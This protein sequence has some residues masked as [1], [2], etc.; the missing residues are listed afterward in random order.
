M[1]IKIQSPEFLNKFKN[2]LFENFFGFDSEKTT[3]FIDFLKEHNVSIGG[4]YI[5]A[6]L[7]DIDNYNAEP[8]LII[9]NKNAEKF[10]LNMFPGFVILETSLSQHN[11][12]NIYQYIQLTF[13]KA[14][15][16]SSCNRIGE[17]GCLIYKENDVYNLL[18]FLKDRE[19]ISLFEIWY[20]PIEDK[21]NIGSIELLKKNRGEIKYIGKY[22]GKNIKYEIY[23]KNKLCELLKKKDVI[24][25][26]RYIQESISNN[27]KDIEKD[28]ILKTIGA[29]TDPYND[30]LDGSE[31]MEIR[32]RVVYAYEYGEIMKY[33]LLSL[34]HIYI[35]EN[36]ISSKYIS[37]DLFNHIS[38]YLLNSLNNKDYQE[39]FDYWVAYFMT[40]YYSK[41]ISILCDNILKSI[42]LNKIEKCTYNEFIEA[43]NY[44][45]KP[46]IKS[47]KIRLLFDIIIAKKFLNN[48]II[49]IS[50][51]NKKIKFNLGDDS[52]LLSD[53]D[54]N[55][56]LFYYKN[57]IYNN[58]LKYKYKFIDL[59]INKFNLFNINVNIHTETGSNSYKKYNDI[60]LNIQE[61]FSRLLRGDPRIIE[62]EF[63]D[64]INAE[65][66]EDVNK[67]IEEDKENILIVSPGNKYITCISKNNLDKLISD[68][69]NYWY[70]DCKKTEPDS[71]GKTSEEYLLEPYIKLDLNI[72][73]YIPYAE[74]F[75]LLKSSN[76]VFFIY[77][78]DKKIKKT[79]TY[80]STRAGNRENRGNEL[81]IVSAW[82]CQE[83]TSI[84]ISH[85]KTLNFTISH[86][87]S[88]ISLN[89]SYSI[90]S[91]SKSSKIK[92]SSSKF[93]YLSSLSSS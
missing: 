36:N 10:I 8:Y 43:V 81:S 50:Y 42:L 57:K 84:N 59:V 20:N 13:I 9:S 72:A 76:K 11:T 26:P 92:S 90:V 34:N 77:N 41:Q 38:K 18:N 63:Y 93:E 73:Y 19:Q 64:L 58:S 52:S 12:G 45:Y 16:V 46:H 56:L 5:T 24:F 70:Y 28:I 37:N 87:K 30:D 66:I 14:D 25:V 44:I 23:K 21:I 80:K 15:C 86:K 79:R 91:S 68:Y 62:R 89:K 40:R 67:F 17:I 22:S 88:K 39:I 74:V 33:F 85:I 6:L 69:N 29:I 7:Y 78:S 49:N 3:K 48:V 75:S 55:V 83:G 1:D 31:D 82:H 35:D 47:V 61:P 27:Y 65:K 51:E 2:N 53:Y 4:E 54:K 71:M 60:L 32:R